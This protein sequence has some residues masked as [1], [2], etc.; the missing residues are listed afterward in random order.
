MTDKKEGTEKGGATAFWQ[1]AA[2]PYKRIFARI[3]LSALRHNIKALRRTLPKETQF[4]AVV[5][6][7]AYGH[8]F[9][10]M[11]E[12]FEETA[13]HYAV[14][15]VEEGIGLR[16]LGITKPVLVLGDAHRDDYEAILRYGLTA[17]ISSFAEAEALSGMAAA[18]LQDFRER[19]KLTGRAAQ[20]SDRPGGKAAVSVHAAVDTGMGRIG[21][22]ANEQGVLE[23]LAAA[24]LPYLQIDG[25]YT[26]FAEA[27]EADQSVTKEQLHRFQEFYQGLCSGGCSPKLVHCANSAALLTGT[28]SGFSMVRAGIAMYGH[29]PS[30]ALSWEMKL[31]PVMEL[32]SYL[33]YVKD[34]EAGTRISYGGVFQAERPMRVGTVSAGYADGYPRRAD[35]RGLFV[36]IHGKR[37]PVIGRVCMDQFMVDLSGVP[38]AKKGDSVTL[39]GRDGSEEI[40]L[41]ELSRASGRFH[42]ELLCGISKRV[43]RV[44]QG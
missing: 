2:F 25:I 14:A 34:V 15:T 31:R 30:D 23:V 43:P 13:D 6:A 20:E 40:S 33:S 3:D 4:C 16:E 9:A 5:K 22:P 42:Y 28:G 10:G 19:E 44:Y 38:D 39:M 32:K 7:D 29:Y 17:T 12:V 35:G 11:K 1:D 27:D 41:E 21:F 18:L 24:K 36:L 8:G 37:C 26:H